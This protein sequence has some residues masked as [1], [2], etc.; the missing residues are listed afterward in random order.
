MAR[1]F[2]EVMQD[3]ASFL[4]VELFAELMSVIIE[5]MVDQCLPGCSEENVNNTLETLW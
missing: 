5:E 3:V 2:D 4:P 1:H